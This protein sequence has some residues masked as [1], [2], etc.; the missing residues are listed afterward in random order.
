M[1]EPVNVLET[2]STW[3]VVYDR[4]NS[5]ANSIDAGELA[6]SLLAMQQLCFRSNRILNGDMAT[7]ALRVVAT[8]RGS[9]EVYLELSLVLAG[10]A[11]I[12]PGGFVVASDYLKAI[13]FGNRVITGIMGIFKLLQGRRYTVN[14]INADTV[15]IIGGDVNTNI[16]MGE[17]SVLQ[18]VGVRGNLQSVVNPLKDRS[19]DSITFRDEQNE[20][21]K[22][23]HDDF[24][25]PAFEEIADEQTDTFDIPTQPLRVTAPNLENRSAKW[26]LNDGKVT[27]WYSIDDVA[28]IQRVIDG[29]ERFGKGDVLV[30]DVQVI[31]TIGGG[32]EIKREYRIARVHGRGA[33]QTQLPL[34]GL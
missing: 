28:F 1:V 14:E 23:E 8:E 18:D 9:V 6:S 5:E 4:D 15:N 7:T 29:E 22:L 26:Q 20:L 10:G 2:T 21:I 17:H 34:D 24:D 25:W 3:T 16:T 27:R 30:C 12:L 32:T 11:H 33:S 13:L 31:E 19:F